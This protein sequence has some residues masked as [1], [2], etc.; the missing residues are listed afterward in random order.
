M[1]SPISIIWKYHLITLFHRLTPSVNPGHYL[2]AVLGPSPQCILCILC[3]LDLFSCHPGWHQSK[4]LSWI[5]DIRL[6]SS[7]HWWCSWVLWQT[8]FFYLD[9]GYI[10][11]IIV[12]KNHWQISNDTE[13]YYIDLYA[14]IEITSIMIQYNDISNYSHKFSMLSM[15]YI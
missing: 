9:T 6:V 1:N 2:F 13:L 8:I 3:D 14:V 5:H 12:K 10:N 11:V 4:P 15:Y 7:I